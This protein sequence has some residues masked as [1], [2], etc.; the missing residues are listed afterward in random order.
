[1]A[2]CNARH[3]CR[4]H[5]CRLPPLRHI[6]PLVRSVQLRKWHRDTRLVSQVADQGRSHL[7]AACVQVSTPGM[8]AN[9]GVDFAKKYRE[10]KLY[11]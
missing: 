7:R 3:P 11:L 2:L 1:M 5:T 4:W 8:E 10:S 9:I 6:Q